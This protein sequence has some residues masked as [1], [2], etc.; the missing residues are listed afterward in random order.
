[1]NDFTTEE[2][3]ILRKLNTPAK[4]QDFLNRIPANFEREGDTC[5]S[6]RIVLRQNRAQCMEGAMFAA[7][8]FRMHGKTPLVVDLETS[9]KDFA[10]VIAVFQVGKLWGAI[11]KSNH[12]SLRYREPIYK[13]IRELVMSYFHEYFNDDGK[14][15]LR[16]YSRPINLSHFDTQ[17]WMTS[18]KPVW[19]IPEY[20]AKIPHIPI[21]PKSALQKL[22]RADEIEIK[23]GKLVEWEKH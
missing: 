20:L 23:V 7:V 17:G 4:I 12:A 11:S 15:T 19:Y 2:K 3:K 22:R 10:H 13:N 18:E 5:F 21:A 14:K 8:A 6:P 1:M 16:S 9:N